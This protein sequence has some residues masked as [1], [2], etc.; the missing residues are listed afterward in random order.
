MTGRDPIR[1]A[2]VMFVLLLLWSSCLVIGLM[3]SPFSW[4]PVQILVELFVRGRASQGSFNTWLR[5]CS[6]KIA[7]IKLG[8]LSSR[9]IPLFQDDSSV[10]Q[11]KRFQIQISLFFSSGNVA[12]V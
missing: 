5:F 10:F 8:S 3:L 9:T 4:G 11:N 1:R 7:I 2:E 6:C 12:S